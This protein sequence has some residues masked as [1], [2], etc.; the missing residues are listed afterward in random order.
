MGV[1]TNLA[2]NPLKGTEAGISD[3]VLPPGIYPINGR[4]QNIDVVEIGYRHSTIQ[5][6]V[7]KDAEG[8]DIVDENGERQIA[9]DES[10]A[11]DRTSSGSPPATASRCTSILRRFG[12]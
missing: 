8:R 6:E 5:V 12:A 4:E 11:D 2:A 7:M 10:V 1:V 3:N 9:D